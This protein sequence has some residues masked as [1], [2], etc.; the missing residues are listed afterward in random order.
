[1]IFGIGTD[2]TRVKRFERWLLNEDMIFRVFNKDEFFPIEPDKSSD[3][4][5]QA[6]LEHY[7]ARFAAK[8]AFAKALGTGLRFNASDVCVLKEESGK[9]YLKLYDS[10]LKL[11]NSLV[12]EKYLIHLSLSHEK[13]YAVA[14]VIIE[15]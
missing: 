1:M 8:E 6:A 4:K 14:T 13:E 10:A 3:R 11:C 9:P 5:I 7:A 15:I 2:I 12:G